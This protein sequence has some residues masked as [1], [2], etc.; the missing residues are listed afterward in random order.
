M[1]R[2]Y[3]L[4]QVVSTLANME[5]RAR[6]WWKASLRDCTAARITGSAWSSRS[7]VPICPAMKSGTWIED[8]RLNRPFYIKQYEEETNLKAYLIPDTSKS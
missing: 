7:I 5:L 4:P 2:K 8:L 3:L 1:T 6:L